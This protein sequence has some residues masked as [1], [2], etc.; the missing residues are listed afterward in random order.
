VHQVV[1]SVGYGL[2]TMCCLLVR[3][4]SIQNIAN[5]TLLE[6]VILIRRRFNVGQRYMAFSYSVVTEQYSVEIQSL[7]QSLRP[8]IVRDTPFTAAIEEAVNI[9]RL[10]IR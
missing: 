2:P 3:R 1:G 10:Q 8:E 5:R 7:L 6:F 4:W 9:E